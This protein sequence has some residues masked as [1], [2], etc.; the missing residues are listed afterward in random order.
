MTMTLTLTLMLGIASC[1]F[2]KPICPPKPEL[3]YGWS[4]DVELKVDGQ[5]RKAKCMVTED[6]DKLMKY[7]ILLEA[8]CE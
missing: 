6:T 1:G 2:S 4:P 7:I 8:Q 5:M 3:N